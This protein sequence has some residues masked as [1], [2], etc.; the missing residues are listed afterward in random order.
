MSAWGSF[1]REGAPRLPNEIDWPRYKAS[2]PAFMTLDSCDA[3][4]LSDDVPPLATLLDQVGSSQVVSELER[5]LLVW[6]LLTAVGTPDYD[7]YST[8]KS[9]RCA[10]I[11]AP[12]EQR[13]IRE[14]LEAEYGSVYYPE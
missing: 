10:A 9:G 2:Q 8:W 13:L 3:L 12:Q 6:E 11:D 7:A 14:A 1:A 5:C 4:A